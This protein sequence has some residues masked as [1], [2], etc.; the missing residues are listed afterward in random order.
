[1]G[2]DVLG[3]LNHGLGSRDICSIALGVMQYIGKLVDVLDHTQAFLL[4]VCSQ[5]P[6]AS[7]ECGCFRSGGH[8]PVSPSHDRTP[9]LLVWVHRPI[10]PVR[11]LEYKS[12]LARFHISRPSI[13]S[14]GFRLL[15]RCTASLYS[16]LYNIFLLLDHC[17]WI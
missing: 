8:K 7:L 5:Y 16:R 10:F 1:M 11:S 17:L 3:V 13:P 15:P 2:L 9:L 4:A 12:A 6:S 14:M